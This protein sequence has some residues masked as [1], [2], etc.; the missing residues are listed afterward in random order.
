V[1]GYV[2]RIKYSFIGYG[3][4]LYLKDNNGLI[5]VFGHLSALSDK[6]EK[7]V[8]EYQYAHAAYSFDNFYGPDSIPVEQG[9][10][11]AFSGQSG[12]GAP[13]IHYEIRDR[14]NLP[15]N[16]LTNGFTLDDSYPP[17]IAGLGFICR[18]SAS[19]HANG[20]RRIYAD[21]EYDRDSRKYFVR[22]PIP[23]F[24]PFGITVKSYDRIRPQGPTL[25]VYKTRLYIDEQLYFESDYEKYDYAD[26]RD[27]DLCFDYPVLIENNKDWQLMYIP[28]GKKYDGSKSVL[29][30]G[31]IFGIGG[32]DEHGLHA[33][34]G[35]FVDASGN[36]AILEFRFA[37]LP[38]FP[39]YDAVW[40]NDSTCY[41]EADYNLKKLDIKD[42]T[43]TAMHNRGQWKP[44]G[45]ENYDIRTN[46]D[47]HL[48]L[49]GGAQRP[50]ALKVDLFGESGW[51]TTG[52]HVI[53][54]EPAGA[55]YTLDYE[56]LDNGI[57]FR[58][59]SDI[60]ISSPPY[61]DIAFEDGYVQRIPTRQ[62]AINKYAAFFKAGVI[63][64]PIIRFDVID[65]RGERV[66]ASV[67]AQ[68]MYCGNDPMRVHES[69]LN[70]FGVVFSGG[71]FYIPT[72]LELVK[73]RGSFPNRKEQVFPVYSVRSKAIPLAD[74]MTVS[75]E[76]GGEPSE[77]LGFYRLTDKKQWFWLGHSIENGKIVSESRLLG[78]FAVL[79]DTEAP[80]VSGLNPGDGKTVKNPNPMI[81]CRVSDDLSQMGDDSLVTILLDGE[82]L[83]PEY[84]PETEILKTQPRRK[85]PDGKHMLE[86]KV[87]DRVGNSRT[88][89]TDFIINTGKQ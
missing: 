53:V 15:L 56:P 5:Y 44:F 26:T 74:H 77:K 9:E 8:K 89:S 3:K 2:W 61:I 24:S 38:D 10:L 69:S 42:I 82:W 6:L 43:V 60:E 18:D 37:Y 85:L 63:R 4:G 52:C 45:K 78:T 79:R 33:V 23:L 68:V 20:Y 41:L 66:A 87:S 7:I 80:R 31:G 73:E 58:L 29:N 1:D 27:V 49:P 84:D 12:Y 35:E 62:Y 39:V 36:T 21:V 48:H 54:N 50:N 81:S 72:Y 51:R 40:A 19:V 34:R 59:S 16:P 70:E 65:P 47:I 13:H 88:V 46:G 86:I 22:E 28:E 55:G 83:I 76:L 30:G 71:D 75:Y 67:P 17:Q 57:Q 32:R 14:N 11:I 64:S 25:N